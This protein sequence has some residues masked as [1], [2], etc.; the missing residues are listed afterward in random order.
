MV[1]T[2]I[3]MGGGRQDASEVTMSREVFESLT[4]EEAIERVYKP[5]HM[6][7]RQEMAGQNPWQVGATV[8]LDA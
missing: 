2:I 1:I 8:T 4:M 5:L 6:V 3:A 7:L